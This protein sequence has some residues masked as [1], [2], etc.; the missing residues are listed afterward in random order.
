[1]SE[2]INKSQLIKNIHKKSDYRMVDIETIV[3]MVFDEISDSLNIDGKVTISKFGTFEKCY[4]SAYVGVNPN[5]GERIAISE[6]NKIRF[7]AS[8]NLKEKINSNNK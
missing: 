2:S 1:M 5:T 3:N 7:T 8:K 6:T 4:Q